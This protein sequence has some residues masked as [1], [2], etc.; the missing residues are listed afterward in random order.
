MAVDVLDFVGDLAAVGGAQLANDIVE[1]VAGQI[2]V[3]LTGG[4]ACQLVGA[5]APGG[6]IQGLVARRRAAEGVQVRGAMAELPD[7]ADQVDRGGDLGDSGVR[8]L[9]RVRGRGTCG[10]RGA[11][12]RAPN[13]R[14]HD[15]QPH[16]E[17][18]GDGLV[19]AVGAAEELLH[20][21]EEPARLRALDDAV[22]VGA[23]DGHDR[24][25]RTG[26]DGARRDDGTLA[27]H[28]PRDRCCRAHRPGIGERQR[29]AGHVVGRE[30]VRSRPVHQVVVS[31]AEFGEVELVGGAD[32]GHD[33]ERLA[34]AADDV[35]RE[36][37]V[38]G[39]RIDA[40]RSSV[41]LGEVRSAAA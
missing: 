37:Q 35:H 41:D 3:K 13:R 40:M 23:A 15:R 4:N 19:E 28:Q 10:D 34:V 22:V 26:P 17:T 32:H 6:G 24:S 7:R 31:I 12:A 25:G 9:G 5:Q 36:P 21:R 2:D 11:R 33:Q 8:N 20:R 1:R 18:L 39:A 14:R 16:S 38:D 27:R 29:G 30:A